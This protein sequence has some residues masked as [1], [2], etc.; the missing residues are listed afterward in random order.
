MITHSALDITSGDGSRSI[1]NCFIHKTL[2][3]YREYQKLLAKKTQKKNASLGEKD[4]KADD[5]SDKK[6]LAE[7]EGL[8]SEEFVR[9][10]AQL[11]N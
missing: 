2:F 11:V 6:T 1:I 7:E 5:G 3:K 9:Q 10:M 4:N 8:A